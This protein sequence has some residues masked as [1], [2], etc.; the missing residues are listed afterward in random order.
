MDQRPPA[1]HYGFAQVP[2]QILRGE[3]YKKKLSLAEKGLY[4]CLKDICGDT[5]ECYYSLRNLALE[6]GTSASTL[7]RLIPALRDAGLISAEKK[8]RG[9]GENKHEIWHIRIVNI[10]Q[11]NDAL[12]KVED[13]SNLKQSSVSEENNVVD[14]STSVSNCNENTTLFQ[15]ET[16]LFQNETK[17]VSFCLPNNTY[18]N[19][20][21][22]E[23]DKR[24]SISASDSTAEHV[25][26]SVALSPTSQSSLSVS[27]SEPLQEEKFPIDGVAT[28]NT[29]SIEQQ[30]FMPVKPTKPS[31]KQKEKHTEPLT[32]KPPPVMPP[33]D[34]PWGTNKC[35]QMFDAWR[36]KT[37]IPKHKL[38]EASTCAKEL[39]IQY[40][41]EEVRRVYN[42]MN[43]DPY[44]I[45][46]GGP[47]ICNVASNIHREIKKVRR[48]TARS[49][50]EP[51][52]MEAERERVELKNQ[53][54]LE[55]LR[56]RQRKKAEALKAKGVQHH[57]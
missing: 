54:A 9:T 17:I 36:G 16:G 13:C 6:I 35:R 44:W 4:S 19:N 3:K 57:G 47:D 12:Y 43:E 39:A 8:V 53:Q 45:G 37:L 49:V 14:A 2:R 21:L 28:R 11:E 15:N 10:W 20:N 29:R 40:T 22:I 51:V 46:R 1:R 26:P 56:E 18:S 34:M 50:V 38:M 25:A 27:S 24:E 30:S 32:P 23:E 52:D 48:Q 5:G 55:A 7:T 42:L 31:S 33:D 41:E